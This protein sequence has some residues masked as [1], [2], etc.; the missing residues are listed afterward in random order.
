MTVLG[1]PGGE[2][3]SQDRHTSA[4]A[5]TPSTY[6]QGVAGCSLLKRWGSEGAEPELGAHPQG[7]HPQGSKEHTSN[8]RALRNISGATVQ[9]WSQDPAAACWALLLASTPAPLHSP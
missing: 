6:K 9:C 2:R 4:G 1:D 7:G 5:P 3:T 8:S